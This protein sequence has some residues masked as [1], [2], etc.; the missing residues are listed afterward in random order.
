MA[1]LKHDLKLNGMKQEENLIL[2]NGIYGATEAKEII[3]DLL[4]SKIKFHSLKNL[5]SIEQLGKSDPV[6]ERRIEQLKADREK[7]DKIISAALKDGAELKIAA[8][9]EIQTIKNK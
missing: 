3:Y 4:T 2:L 8:N 1:E 6:S 7:L 5:R 9:I